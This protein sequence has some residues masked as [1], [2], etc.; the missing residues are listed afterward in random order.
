MY[1]LVL[2]KSLCPA[3]RE[4]GKVHVCR[5]A[6]VFS[7]CSD[8]FQIPRFLF[9]RENAVALILTRQHINSQTRFLKQT[10]LEDETQHSP[11]NLKLAVDVAHL[12]F[13]GETDGLFSRIATSPITIVA[14]W[15]ASICSA[16]RVLFCFADSLIRLASQMN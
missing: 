14:L 1:R 7:Q 3:I 11:Q 16:T 2:E 12:E 9:R 6:D 8:G 10:P 5:G 4:S 15:A 13:F